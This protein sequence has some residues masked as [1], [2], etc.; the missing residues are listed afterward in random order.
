M[1][2]QLKLFVDRGHGYYPVVT[3]FKTSLILVKKG[4]G[5]TSN[6]FIWVGAMVTKDPI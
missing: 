1:K 6:L 4:N 2:L 5:K 3:R